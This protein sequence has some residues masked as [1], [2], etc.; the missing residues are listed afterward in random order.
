M[1]GERSVTLCFANAFFSIS[2]F[3]PRF[4]RSV[5]GTQFPWRSGLLKC[6]AGMEEILFKGGKKTVTPSS[7]FHL[8]KFKLRQTEL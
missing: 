3:I 7:F 6:E 2:I 8:V 4:W 1:N 5:R